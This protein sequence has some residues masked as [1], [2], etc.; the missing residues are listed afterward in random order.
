TDASTG[1]IT[2]WSWDFG[3]GATSS[4]ANPTHTYANA[5]IYAVTL[6]TS[7]AYGWNASTTMDAVHVLPAPVA[8]FTVTPAEGNAPLAVIFTDTSAGNVT[9]WFW[10]F[11]DGSTSTDPNPG[12]IYASAGTYTV[13]LNA[14]NAYGF[15]VSTVTDAISVLLAP[16]ANFT[17]TPGEGNAPLAVAF[18]DASV[19]NITAWVWNFGD[20]NTSNEQ[21]PSHIYVTAGTYTVSLNVSNTYGFNVS[22]V[23]EGVV[24]LPAPVAGFTHSPDAGNAPLTVQFNDT[25]SGNITGWAWDFGDGQTSTE[26]NPEHLYASAGT[27]T[28]SLNSSNAYGFNVSTVA[29]A[30][31]VLPAPTAGFTFAPDEGNAPL[32]VQFNDTSSGNVTA[33]R[34][35]FG[36]GNESS[37]R[38]PS[39]TY[40]TQ[41]T[42]AVS[43]NA[44][45]AYGFNVSSV[46][47]AVLV[48]SPPT[49]NFTYTPDEGNAP[50][51]VTFTD[52]STGNVTAWHWDFGDGNTSTEQSPVHTYATEGTYTVSLNASNAYGFNVS[53][54]AD[55]VQVLSAPVAGF[56]FTPDEGNA[57]LNVTF[58]D[59]SV[60]NITVRAWDFGDGQTSAEQSPSH[61]YATAGIYTVTLNASNAYGSSVS[62]VADG[63]RVLPAPVANFTYAPSEGNAPLTVT[64]TDASAG[65]VTAWHWVFGDG[66]TSAEQNPAHTYA[67]AGIYTVSLNVSNTYGFDVSTVTDAISVLLAPAA[68]FTYAPDEG[69]APLI[70]TFTDTSSGNVT[71]WLWGFGD[72]NAST[73]QSPVHN[74]ASAGT[75][76]VTLNAS[77]SYGSNTSVIT[78]AISVLPT[79]VANFTHTPDE[80]NAPLAV[81][82]NDASTGNVTAWAWDFG[83]G[84]TSDKQNPS[85]TYEIPGAYTITLNVSNAYGFDVSTVTDG[86]SV[87]PA[88]IANFTHTPGEGNAPLT[89]QFNDASLG[90]VTAWH[91][92]FGD[93]NESI[94]QSPSH[95]YTTAGI[96]TISLNASNT[97]GFNVSTVSDAA[98]VLPP[99]AANFTCT[100]GEGNAPLTVTF[101]DASAGN[102]TAWHWAFGD[103]NTSTDRNTTHI[104]EAAGT[105][106]VSLNVSNAYGSDIATVSDAVLVLSPPTASFTFAP[107]EGNAPLAVQFND[108]SSGSVTAWLWTFGD[109]QTSAEQH[110]VHTYVS[111]GAY[112]VSLNASNAYG[113]N[114]STVMDGVGVLPAPGAIFTYAPDEGN[115]PL[116]V[117]FTDASAGNVTAWTWDFG[118]GNVSSLQ[119]PTHTYANAGIYTVSL[120]SSN[121]YG[122][123]ASVVAD[124]VRVL[125]AP[126]A[127]FTFVPGEGN[128]PLV[129]QFADTSS[130]NVTAW[131][132]DFGDGNASTD[133]NATHIY[134]NPGTFTVT[135]NASNAY[136][137]NVSVIADAISVLPAPVAGFTFAPSEGNAPLAV[138]FTDI[139]SG[140]VI[141]W[142]W[143]FGDGEIS[144]EQNPSHTYASAGTYTVSLNASNAYGFNISTVPSAV[145]VLPAPVA[146]F[147]YTPDEGNAPLTVTFTDS[148]TGNI[149][150]WSWDFGDGNT[151]TD[152]NATHTYASAGTYIVSLSASNAYGFNVST[153]T[154][155]VQVLSA[156]VAGFAYVPDEGNA[157]LLVQ[158]TDTSAGNVTAWAWDFGDGQTSEEQNPAHTYTTAGTYMVSLNASNA[159]GFDASVSAGVINVLT[160][161]V[162]GFTFAPG[163]GNTPLAVTFTDASTGNITAWSWDFGD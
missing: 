128:A 137:F 119:N 74:Y 146:N 21:S 11:G 13:T 4:D 104:Y 114:V 100:P 116:T 96:Y 99:P 162:A 121:V 28:V 56:T 142:H 111:A 158:F 81:Q 77:N 140:D 5:G 98:L 32:T 16:A 148:S 7:N 73:E 40:V 57:A 155:G 45:N 68:N 18:T 70:V 113:W 31:Q 83:D 112:T 27:Y 124:A 60:G 54:A 92:D 34:W 160:A 159:Y 147:T 154:G 69:N 67:N 88:P 47:D 35:D 135:L 79:P 38:N 64:F 46:S 75:Y 134:A 156:P 163:E 43:L 127:G 71:A 50:L 122:F 118:D 20:G 61:T 25:S 161:P 30:V 144:T 84:T 107:Q 26:Q 37:E 29:S 139:S 93:G 78:N 22:T 131:L 85:H 66:N 15:N 49:A 72:G 62:V 95:T 153:T 55:G 9:A 129:V 108:T 102:V 109:G 3:D 63:I 150:A 138:Q 123:N 82:F 157:P 141:T 106:T 133:R 51:T 17:F 143:D 33:W 58:T 14:S 120:N 87:L 86:V 48:L 8:N 97:Y 91:W 24:V 126:S 41:G 10:D 149:T 59:A 115:A 42:Y 44:S 80:G 125:P 151:S 152:R 39:H 1:N 94:E 6:N 89:V 36:D 90:N 130:G 132:W 2:A 52:A 103:G 117:T 12:H 19:G 145:S 105:Y 23:T 110:P 65:N 76:T 53:T 136:G 101:T